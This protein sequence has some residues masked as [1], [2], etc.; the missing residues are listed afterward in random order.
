VPAP[1]G[2]DQR[3]RTPPTACVR[4]TSPS[5]IRAPRRRRCL[6]ISL[7][8]RPGE[9]LALVGENGSG[10]TTLIKLLTRLYEPPRAG[11]ASTVSM[12]GTGTRAPAPPH[13][14]DLPGLRALSVAGGREHRRRRREHFEDAGGWQEAAAKGMADDF[15][16]H[17][18]EG[19]ETQLG[20][21]FKGGRELSGRPVAEDRAVAGLHAP[22]TPTS[23]CSTSPPPPWT[24]KPR[25]RSSSTFQPQP[26]IGWYDPDLAPVLD[27]AHGLADRT[28]R[29]WPGTGA[30]DA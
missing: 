14:G 29:R 28:H 22:V 4:R 7:H 17:L 21:W 12:F 24:P 19:Y 25:R 23:S 1:A 10:K 18:P 8:V 15:I 2:Q 9:S 20:R 27:C 11:S 6:D 30:G 5:A 16:D 3:S 13:R 26:E